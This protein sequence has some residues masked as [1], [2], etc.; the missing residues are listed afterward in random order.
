V[1]Q[2]IQVVRGGT[3]R[4]AARFAAWA[5][6]PFQCLAARDIYSLLAT[7]AFTTH[8]LYLNLGYWKTARNIDE[9]CGALAMLVAE[10][11]AMGP[12]DDVVDVG[13]GFAD[14]DML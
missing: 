12:E 1:T 10:A 5:F 14:Q 11:A 9:A 4:D 8:G 2:R 13:F 3:L 7:R 6:T